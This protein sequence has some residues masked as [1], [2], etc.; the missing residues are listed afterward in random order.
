MKQYIKQNKVALK[1]AMA[2]LLIGV[3]S[4]SIYYM[5]ISSLLKESIQ[6]SLM[7]IKTFQYNSIL[8]DLIVMSLL[9][10]LSFFVVGIPAGLFYVFYESFSIGFLISIFWT[11]FHLK[12]LFLILMYLLLN[13]VL[14]TVLML[15]FIHKSINISRYIIGL[16]IYKRDEKII[17]KLIYSVKSCLLLIII[18]LIIN[19]ILYFVSPLVLNGFIAIIK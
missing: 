12:G 8:K 6:T 1:I 15:L 19:V 11:S 7:N 9:L 14:T 18:V 2:I 17:N 5:F 3:I 13:K 16:F 10:V 4:G